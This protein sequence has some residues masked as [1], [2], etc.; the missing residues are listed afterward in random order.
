MNIRGAVGVQFEVLN[1]HEALHGKGHFFCESEHIFM[2]FFLSTLCSAI[3]Q[4]DLYLKY[5]AVPYHELVFELR[6]RC[7]LRIFIFRY[8]AAIGKHSMTCDCITTIPYVHT[9]V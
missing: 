8:N 4:V 2:F 9:I 3:L 1:E 6:M 5:I 7:T